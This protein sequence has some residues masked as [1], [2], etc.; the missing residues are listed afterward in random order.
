MVHIGKILI[1]LGLIIA[2]TGVVV[3]LAD[4]LG[5]HLGR[6][7]GDIVYRKGN[8][9]VYIPVMTMILLSVVLSLLLYFLRK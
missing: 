4:K 6:L 5:L 1:G 9:T 8:T 3:L 7:P 2:L